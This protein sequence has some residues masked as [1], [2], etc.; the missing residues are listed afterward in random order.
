MNMR[1]AA[2]MIT[3]VGL[4]GSAS[5]QENDAADKV[6]Q[7]SVAAEA[8]K[9]SVNQCW[10]DWLVKN[11]MVE[12]VNQTPDGAVRII[13]KK[14]DVVQEPPDSRKWVRAR[15][16]LVGMLHLSARQAIA[17]YIGQSI[18]TGEAARWMQAGGEEIPVLTPAVEAASLADKARVLAGLEL[19]SQIK[20]YDP[21]WDGT[22]KSEDQIREKAVEV[23]TQFQQALQ[24]RSE[25]M[26]M[27]STTVVQCEGPAEEDGTA[28]ASKYEVLIGLI[29][30]PRLARN[31]LALG[32]PRFKIPPGKDRKAL[33][34]RFKEFS[35]VNKD[36]L[37]NTLGSRVWTDENGEMVVVGFGAAGATELKDADEDR[38]RLDA[39]AAIA[40]FAGEAIVATS[41]A[42]DNFSY[43][44][45]TDGTAESFDSSVYE[46]K[47]EARAKTLQLKGAYRVADW[48]GKHPVTGAAIQVVGYAWKPSAS[49]AAEAAGELLGSQNSISSGEYG[50]TTIEAPVKEGASGSAVDY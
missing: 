21:S 32:D 25:V 28:S 33:A 8:F 1:V 23:G 13:V 4:A 12:G 40:R 44:R 49:T 5:A 38:A 34:E 6:A 48:R 26:A 50:G 17:N 16:Y 10:D 47:I 7:G 31:A 43:Q 14:S 2:C 20:K 18:S 24:S 9:I 22:G 30:T 36:W 11:S 42:Q 3:L 29:W 35:S 15:N 39:V 41:D 46:R 45:L 27:G 37:V 19:D